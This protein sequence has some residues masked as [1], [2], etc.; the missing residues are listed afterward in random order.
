ME[1]SF[2]LFNNKDVCVDLMP[3]FRKDIFSVKSLEEKIYKDFGTS[4][5]NIKY[6]YVEEEGHSF[7]IDEY[8]YENGNFEGLFK[9]LEK[10][11]GLSA[12]ELE[13][14]EAYN[15]FSEECLEDCLKCFEN[16][17]YISGI[18]MSGLAEDLA[19]IM[20]D[21]YNVPTCVSDFFDYDAFEYSLEEEWEETSWGVI[22]KFGN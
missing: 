2:T 4:F 17:E 15:E 9:V 18:T 14:L 20:F 21:A 11:W 3:L 6:V 5:E 8:F 7:R 19:E 10:L 16:Y 1:I 22:R 12:D 13:H